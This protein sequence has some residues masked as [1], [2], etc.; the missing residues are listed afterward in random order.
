MILCIVLISYIIKQMEE[1]LRLKESSFL[2]KL[3]CPQHDSH[4]ITKG[5]TD[6]SCSKK[7]LLCDIC[8]RED[9]HR[10][11]SVSI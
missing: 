8:Q 10:E 6:L 5:C 11:H 4:L 3:K 7:T 1:L 9:P 2:P